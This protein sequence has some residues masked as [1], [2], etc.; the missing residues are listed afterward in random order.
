MRKGDEGRNL[1][2]I[3]SIIFKRFS[4]LFIHW[5]A[6]HLAALPPCIFPG[7]V[8]RNQ[9]TDGQAGPPG[10]SPAAVVSNTCACSPCVV[11]RGSFILENKAVVSPSCFCLPAG[12]FPATDHISSSCL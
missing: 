2:G 3:V 5:T 7:L 11:T 8:F 10:P 9:E 1:K 6:G 12:S 4:S